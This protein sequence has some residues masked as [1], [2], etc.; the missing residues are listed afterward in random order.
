MD[1]LTKITGIGAATA[2]KLTAAGIDSFAKLAVATPAQ[3]EALRIAGGAAD[4]QA[5]ISA[6]AA[7]APATIDLNTAS[8]DEIA[9]Q[10]AKL[11]TARLQLS[12]VADA[13]VLAHGELQGLS[14]DATPE[15]II[16]A[17]GALARARSQVELA[18]TDAR[19]LFGVPDDAPLPAALIEE[20][21][22]L[23]ALPP[24]VVPAPS[25][26]VSDASPVS[27]E[28]TNVDGLLEWAAGPELDFLSANAGSFDQAASA[29]WDFVRPKL[30]EMGRE[31]GFG[32]VW[33]HGFRQGWFAAESP[34]RSV[35]L[36]AH[37]VS[38]SQIL[39]E[40]DQAH[41]FLADV[42]GQARSAAAAGELAEAGEY[43]RQHRTEI[44]AGQV[45]LAEML[46]GINAEIEQLDRI[47]VTAP[48][49]FGV[50]VVA[51]VD[52]RWRIG[53][54]FNK[55]PTEFEPGELAADELELLKADPLLTVREVR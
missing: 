1:D 28:A 29:A 19:A 25:P 7:L 5:L 37:E 26:D 49:E 4:H 55:T 27:V 23:A 40:Q 11:E 24:F 31:K 2:K 14:A 22:P 13:V 18:I 38:T 12:Q 43:L 42:I 32:G 48:V 16:H 35:A 6:A 36:P 15:E 46:A 33:A 8:A 54:Q 34:F 44:R 20:L 51:K 50:E 41:A 17:E 39:T 30:L 53:R 9:V 45:L 21:A 3:I 10:A 47:Q 52:S